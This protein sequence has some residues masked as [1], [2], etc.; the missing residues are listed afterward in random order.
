MRMTEISFDGATPIDGYGPGFFRVAGQVMEGAILVTPKGAR[1]WGGYKDAVPLVALVAEVDVVFIGTGSEI[2]HI[3]SEL[4]AELE[5]AGLGVESMNS[6]A[7]CRTYNVLLSE[8]RRVAA[9]VL[10][11]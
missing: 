7:A 11:V 8:G 3:P 9:A 2:A 6:P 5:A 4:R 1:S 10:P